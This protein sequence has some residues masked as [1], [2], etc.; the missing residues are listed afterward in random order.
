MDSFWIALQFLGM[1]TSS[2]RGKENRDMARRSGLLHAIVQAQR[3]AEKK[4]VAQLREI[5]R[6]QTQAAKAAEKARKEYERAVAADQ[7][8]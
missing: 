1:Q 3:E 4:R 6:A 8:G 7:K 5:E 2:R